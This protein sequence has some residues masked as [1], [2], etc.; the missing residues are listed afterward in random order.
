MFLYAL[1]RKTWNVK[2]VTLRRLQIIGN[3]VFGF[4]ARVC[5]ACATSIIHGDGKMNTHCYSAASPK[6]NTI[7]LIFLHHFTAHALPYGWRFRHGPQHF[8]NISATWN[9]QTQN[10]SLWIREDQLQKTVEFVVP[11]HS[12]FLLLTLGFFIDHHKTKKKW[13]KIETCRRPFFCLVLHA[14]PTDQ[15]SA[16]KPRTNRK[17]R[18]LCCS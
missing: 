8:A 2:H 11:V 5:Y 13:S 14:Q 16:V 6:W 3:A 4:R 17:R 7:L 12:V 18:V 15:R 9:K 10:F 1:K